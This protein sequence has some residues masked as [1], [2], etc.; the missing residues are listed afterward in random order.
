[1]ISE[2]GRFKERDTRA[3]IGHVPI[4]TGTADR[5]QTLPKRDTL[6]LEVL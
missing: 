6:C 3:P 4:N 2:Q 1:M 5:K